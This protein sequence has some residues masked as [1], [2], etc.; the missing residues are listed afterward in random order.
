M[1]TL[2]DIVEDRCIFQYRSLGGISSTNDIPKDLI[3]YLGLKT[4][5][6]KTAF[7]ELVGIFM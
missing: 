1:E 5:E 2:E 7:L 6:Q 3:D 4:F